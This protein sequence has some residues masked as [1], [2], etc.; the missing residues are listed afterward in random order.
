MGV[1]DVANM[2]RK[3]QQAKSKMSKVE[4]AAQVGST[5]VVMDGLYSIDVETD[6]EKLISSVNLNKDPEELVK[7]VAKIL[8]KEF[9]EASKDAKK[10]VEEKLANMDDIK[11]LF[12]M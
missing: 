5:T 11:N 1:F 6:E 8:R 4:G 3:A 10:R 2:V 9:K 7:E 12:Q